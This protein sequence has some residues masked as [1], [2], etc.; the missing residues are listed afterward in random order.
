MTP[1]WIAVDWGTSNLRAWAVDAG[2]RVA[3]RAES[4]RGA[5]FLVRDE[6]E[7]ALLALIS[8]WLPKTGSLPVLVSGMAG[9]RRGWAEAPYIETPCDLSE[10]YRR[11]VSVPTADPRLSVE[12]VPGLCQREAG[13][14]DV[15]RGEEVQL[16]GFAVA[17]P[18]FTGLVGL[19]GTHSKWVEFDRGQVS[20]FTT[21]LSGEL[22]EMLAKHSTLAEALDG[23]GWDETSFMDGVVS[24]S[25]VAFRLPAELFKL[26]AEA[27][28][29]NRDPS[30]CRAYLS[31]LITGAEVRAVLD[32]AISGLPVAL[33][34]AP[35][36]TRLYQQALEPHDRVC[37]V[38]S[39]E[40]ATLAG[41]AA[42]HDR[43]APLGKTGTDLP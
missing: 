41:L 22:F 27:L 19:P 42:L 30:W 1:G 24:G 34:G 23:D 26:R 4:D 21:F 43:N 35:A 2:G 25:L 7:P 15:M 5:K 40:A 28:L 12:I 37:R 38:M 17:E 18:E 6:F 33:I 9:S 16:L 36:L 29:N 3:A 31:G 13:R 39:G 32:T 11:R 14:P 20:G 10:L 8:D